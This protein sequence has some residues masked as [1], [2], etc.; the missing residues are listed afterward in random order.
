MKTKNE[1]PGT[2]IRKIS[3]IDRIV[4]F[5]DVELPKGYK[6]KIEAGNMWLEI[7]FY[8]N[9]KK[10]TWSFEENNNSHSSYEDDYNDCLDFFRI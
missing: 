6:E 4:N 5:F 3:K 2:E 10:A 9:N 8:H 7:K 1:L